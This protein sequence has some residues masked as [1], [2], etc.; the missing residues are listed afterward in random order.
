MLSAILDWIRK[1]AKEDTECLSHADA[2]TFK[3]LTM[4]QSDTDYDE[5]KDELVKFVSGC[6]LL[7]GRPDYK[8]LLEALAV[9][10]N[11]TL[12]AA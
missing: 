4:D 3:L 6:S 5:T 11:S 1:I 9:T 8:A 2:L 10:D 12:I 7:R